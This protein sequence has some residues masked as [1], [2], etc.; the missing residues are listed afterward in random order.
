MSG[1]EKSHGGV[2]EPAVALLGEAYMVAFI[3][4]LFMALIPSFFGAAKP[5]HH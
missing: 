3:I 1:H 2:V 5:A 4:F